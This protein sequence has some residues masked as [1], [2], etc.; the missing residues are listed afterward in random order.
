[1]HVSPSHN[2]FYLFWEALDQ[3]P[4]YKLNRLEVTPKQK[5]TVFS[6]M[7]DFQKIITFYLFILLFRASLAEYG[8]SQARHLIGATAGGLHHS[9]SNARSEYF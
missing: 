9:H 3:I 5:T 7:R 4:L 6:L 2:C 8:D 1:M